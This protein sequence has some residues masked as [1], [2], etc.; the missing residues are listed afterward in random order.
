MRIRVERARI[1]NEECC[2]L[3]S[4]IFK[5]HTFPSSFHFLS[6]SSSLGLYSAVVSE[7]ILTF[8]S[9]II[10]ILIVVTNSDTSSDDDDF[11][12]FLLHFHFP[13]SLGY[14]LCCFT[15]KNHHHPFNNSV[16]WGEKFTECLIFIF[17]CYFLGFEFGIWYRRIFGVRQ[18][19]EHEVHEFQISANRCHCG[20]SVQ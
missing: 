8:T 3:S 11:N 9:I 17:L 2:A 6:S 7:Q 15:T 16:K 18:N 14:F 12:F 10:I 19:S 1:A 4:L 5:F 20:S 13:Y